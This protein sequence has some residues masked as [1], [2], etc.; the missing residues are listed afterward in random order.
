MLGKPEGYGRRDGCRGLLQEP[1]KIEMALS[2]GCNDPDA[3]SAF[4][5][6]QSTKRLERDCLIQP[7]QERAIDPKA[8]SQREGS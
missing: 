1:N 5:H 2:G 3:R 8:E 4:W 6:T 7:L